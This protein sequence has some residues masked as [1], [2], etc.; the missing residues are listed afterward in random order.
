MAFDDLHAALMA[1]PHTGAHG[2]EGLIRD[3]L[4]ELTGQSF[5]L[6]KSG[7]Q[8]GLDMIGDPCGSGL[9]IGM[10]GKHYASKTRLPLDALKAK[11]NDAA[12]TFPGMDLWLLATTR[13][14]DGGDANS[15]TQ[16]GAALGVEVTVFDWQTDGAVP[17][18]LATLCAAAPTSTA[19]HLRTVADHDLT[20]VRASPWYASEVERLRDALRSAT[21]GL[22]AARDAL[23]VWIRANL[24]DAAAARQAFDSYATLQA[25]ATRRITRTKISAQL[26]DWWRNGP[27]STAALLGQ[28]GMG[29]TWAALAWWLE[30]SETDPN[31]PLTLVVP[32]RDV[33]SFDG[34]ALLARTLHHA[35]RLRDP[36]FW[37]R[38]LERWATLNA[39]R[40][41]FLLILDG[42][43]QK[44]S[45]TA[46]SD[47]LVSL[48]TPQWKDRAAIILTCR[49]D[50]W[51]Q[52][53]KSLSDCPVPITEVPV[54]HFDDVELDAIL[55]SHGIEQKDLA[56]RVRSLIRVPRLSRLAIERRATLSGGDVT[57]ERLVYEDW[58]H[59][60][61]RA[62][63]ALS[64]AEFQRFV[65]QLGE[66]LDGRIGPPLTRANL[67]ERL[68]ADNGAPSE[69]FEGVLS[70]LIDGGW[71]EPTEEPN[72][73]HL[74][75]GRVP[76]A[77]GLAL[78]EQLRRAEP[79]AAREEVYADL[80]EPLQDSDLA[81]AIL[82][83][84]ATFAIL[85]TS[86][87]PAVRHL[88]LDRWTKAQNFGQNDFESFWRLIGCAP[89]LFIELAEND[90]F[91]GAG[92]GREDE[93]L[94][95]G[96]GNAWRW[97]DVA[98]LWERRLVAW[99]S[100]YWLDP[101]EGEI[102][103]QVTNDE[104]AAARRAAT[105]ARAATAQTEGA[106]A[107][108]GIALVEVAPERQAWGSYRA[109]ELLSWLPRAPLIEVF[110][111]W[112][113][114][115]AILGGW[116]QFEALA[117]VLRW[118]TEDFAT[119]ETALLARADA[120][121]ASGG[122]VARAAAGSLL[123]ALASPQAMAR[124]AAAFPAV[125]L[126]PLVHP[127]WSEADMAWRGDGSPLAA[128]AR[129]NADP[130]DPELALPE[131]WVAR[132]NELAAATSDEA[133][134]TESHHSALGEAR[135][136]LGRWAPQA[137]AALERRAAQAAVT[138]TMLPE[139][140]S[141][142][143]RQWQR[144]RGKAAARPEPRIVGTENLLRVISV[145]DEPTLASWRVIATRAEALGLP[146]DFARDSA[147]FV[148]ASATEQISLLKRAIGGQVPEHA[149]R[150]FRTPS[151][152]D[153][154]LIAPELDSACPP[155]RLCAW[156]GYL[157]KHARS[158]L[159]EGWIPLGRLLDHPDLS[160]RVAALRIA[161]K[162]QDRHLA[163]RF[164]QSG[165]SFESEMHR[166]EA[167]YGSL[168]LTLS[169]AAADGLA[170]TRVHP[171]ALG[172]L[173][174]RYPDVRH[175]R[176]AFADHVFSELEH[177][178]TANSRHYPRALLAVNRGWQRII[179]DHGPA[180]MAWMRP[181]T[182]P[183][184]DDG[185]WFFFEE[186]PYLR[187]LEAVDVLAPGSMA[188]AIRA[189]L[190]NG[191]GSNLRSGDLYARATQLPG[192]HGEEIR[193]LALEEANDDKKLF[194]FA[195]GLQ[196]H[197][198]TDWLIEQIKRD[199]AGPMS[200]SIARALTLAGFL[201]PSDAAELLWQTTLAAPP[202][203]GWLAEV[204]ATSKRRYQRFTWARHW[205]LCFQA[206][207]DVD[208]T[209]A[210]HLLLTRCVDARFHMDGHRPSPATLATWPWRKAHLWSF[211]WNDVRA[212][213]E[214]HQR[215]LE[216]AFLC[217]APPLSNQVPRRR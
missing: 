103:G 176:D 127:S 137:L 28:E 191:R 26:D 182:H 201:A 161:W 183:E 210:A 60:H 8:G 21:I 204:H 44:W 115:R 72:R 39:P 16:L 148:D 151:V 40:P 125:P 154:E 50:H 64:H 49:P 188:R 181:F 173:A 118:N 58:R 41:L 70:E 75:T 12:Q 162:A 22:A 52:R 13:A 152:N 146:A 172:E 120:L 104:A 113:L 94:V 209:Y 82:R 92:T 138:A 216:K 51:N 53:L 199:L 78:V 111:A 9:I 32:A 163:D 132:I 212:A 169:T 87:P 112:A 48:A 119:A 65:S 114:T 2:F 83:H 166:E 38:R 124:R 76:A 116:R 25:P 84:A 74:N 128:V 110:T 117:W 107:A 77:L 3:A 59:R 197:G 189:G 29:K 11:L 99:F 67:L 213:I 123:D 30:R 57:P 24:R 63:Q 98:A 6:M 66:T 81:V 170:G 79:Q 158:V 7:P 36:N 68:S 27:T 155:K 168:L 177:L 19:H 45:F 214:S 207:N 190:R 102:L 34:P 31:F 80:L 18:S 95:K 192:P 97:P 10:E 54:G 167:A 5:R 150:L 43:N 46:W 33:D 184:K 108:F 211:G 147:R 61:H 20:A 23:A 156:L 37:R 141:W 105:Q 139:K 85:D 62:Q 96:I 180:L 205:N 193:Q 73:F 15:L 135:A 90:W 130:G 198:Q 159:P 93:I 185:P 175:Y 56:P 157:N 140:P 42:L 89:E 126:S 122:T 91:G 195:C 215:A 86:V 144:I 134:I 142:L 4:A 196:Q 88:L 200:G 69:Q 203:T 14:I 186:F 206:S 174:H 131:A 171:D 145:L 106:S 202:A 129:L 143:V 100:R 55:A 160:V 136:A 47:L 133:L 194:A 153:L 1:L 208:R 217:T 121:I 109:V 101:L 187:A 165:W 149:R 17:P 178:H 35:T 179:E 71:L 164:E